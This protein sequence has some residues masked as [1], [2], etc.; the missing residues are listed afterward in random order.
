MTVLPHKTLH[1]QV[2]A[3]GA[4]LW[5]V[6]LAQLIV[7]ACNILEYACRFRSGVHEPAPFPQTLVVRSIHLAS[8]QIVRP[9][10]TWLLQLTMHLPPASFRYAADVEAS[11][12]QW[13]V[14]PTIQLCELACGLN[15]LV[16]KSQA[17]GM[18]NAWRNFRMRSG[19]SAEQA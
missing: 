8:T 16:T 10:Q 11:K 13:K 12:V 7:Q 3:E 17:C 19:P 5:T 2:L 14:F 1:S 4:W 15:M 18:L 6:L 9:L